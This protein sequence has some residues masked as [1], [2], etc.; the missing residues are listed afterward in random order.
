M[1]HRM[2]ISLFRVEK[3]DQPNLKTKKPP[4]G[5]HSQTLWMRSV[6]DALVTDDNVAAVITAPTG[7]RALLAADRLVVARLSLG[8]DDG[9]GGK[10]DDG[11]SG[12]RTAAVLGMSF[13]RSNG[14][15]SGSHGGDCDGGY[16][17]LAKHD[18]SFRLLNSGFPCAADD[19]NLGVAGNFGCDHHHDASLSPD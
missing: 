19:F 14:D 5:G 9:A 12:N 17:K 11:T 7:H 18:D 8:S 16:C 4:E 15:G 13:I 6:T 1:E 2:K 10:A 3:Q